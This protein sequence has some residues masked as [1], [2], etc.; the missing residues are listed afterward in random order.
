M[1]RKKKGGARYTET[2]LLQQRTNSA[3]NNFGEEDPSGSWETIATRLA[4][5]HLKSSQ[6]TW[7][8][9]NDLVDATHLIELWHDP[10]AAA[11]TAQSHRVLWG[12][13][14]LRVITVDDYGNEHLEVG[15]VC[16]E[17]LGAVS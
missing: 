12:S 7:Q 15:I 4:A 14:I 8:T 2:V 10:T 16:M 1:R 17:R 13:R 6:Q 11:M 5:V 9:G 3:L